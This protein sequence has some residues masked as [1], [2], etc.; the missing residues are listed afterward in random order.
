[1]AVTQPKVAQHSRELGIIQHHHVVYLFLIKLKHGFVGE[2]L[3][4]ASQV[5]TSTVSAEERGVV[6]ALE[7][8]I[9]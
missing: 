9:V 5:F 2:M 8:Y 6:V 4:A 3:Q 7:P 1:M